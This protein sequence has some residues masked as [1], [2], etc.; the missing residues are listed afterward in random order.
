MKKSSILALSLAFGMF[1][2]PTVNAS[3]TAL[4]KIDNIQNVEYNE[5]DKITINKFEKKE[6]TESIDSLL[7]EA[8][9]NLD[10]G[11]IFKATPIIN[12]I[13]ER[14]SKDKKTLTEEQISEIQDLHLK[15]ERVFT[16]KE[17]L[18]KIYEK[19][20]KANPDEAK[21]IFDDINFFESEKVYQKEITL[22]KILLNS[23]H[24]E[25]ATL[26][27]IKAIE[28]IIF[29]TEDLGEIRTI[30]NDFNR[31]LVNEEQI[32]E[33]NKIVK[34]VDD[35]EFKERLKND[36]ADLENRMRNP[37][38]DY[39]VT[40]DYDTGVSQEAYTYS[41]DPDRFPDM[42]KAAYDN[43]GT[44]YVWGGTSYNGWDCSGFVYRMYADYLG[45]QLNRTAQAQSYMGREVSDLKPGDL[46][47][48][49]TSRNNRT[50]V[51]MYVGESSGSPMMIHASSPKS[52]TKIDDISQPWYQ[53][54]LQ[55]IKRIVE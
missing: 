5:D 29:N 9:E 48:F 22:M 39:I 24:E 2:S 13:E 38:P 17:E 14:Y 18:N 51:G 36:Y 26:E 53:N 55:V 12:K 19:M 11:L 31:E 1:A 32:K 52:G 37:E 47:F 54:R 30:I 42:I 21:K 16:K 27:E 50:H 15:K 10:N 20:K 28:E 40:Y 25:K 4:D 6:D 33:Y 49:G 35:L 7:K 41:I 44:R 23:K 45:V 3:G 8:N 43:L 34:Y 46:L